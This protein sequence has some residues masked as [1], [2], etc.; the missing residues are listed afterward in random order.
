MRFLVALVIACTVGADVAAQVGWYVE[1]GAGVGLES[2]FKH[3]GH[4][5]DTVCYPTNPDCPEH[6]GY[7]WHYNI[8]AE[9]GSDVFL[10]VGHR[11][12]RWR[13]E[14]S[15]S[16]DVRNLEH[17]FSGLTY[18]G[19]QVI[20]PRLDNGVIESI[21]SGIGSLYRRSARFNA[22]FDPVNADRRLRPYIGAGVGL[23]RLTATDVYFSSQFSCES[24]STCA[25]N[26][27]F[28]NSLQDAD[29]SAILLSVFGYAGADCYLTPNIAAGLRF[30]SSHTGDLEDT[31]AYTIHPVPDLMSTT[32]FGPLWLHALVATLR[33]EFG[34]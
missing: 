17:S 32:T 29:M 16:Q 23:T 20:P 9:S 14:L 25:S 21:Q 8:T 12:Y 22:Y 7:M 18:L 19:G 28:Y 4:N 2:S 26:L 10:T 15:G 11:R 24:S 6:V 31:A 1:L 30:S 13:V 3:E 33:Y 5:L 27:Y 34:G